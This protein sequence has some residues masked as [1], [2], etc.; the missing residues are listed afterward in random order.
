MECIH[1]AKRT[2][3]GVHGRDIHMVKPIHGGV[4]TGWRH[5]HGGDIYTAGYTHG[6]DILTVETYRVKRT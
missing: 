4:Y 3:G 6:S 2:P 5:T 1:T